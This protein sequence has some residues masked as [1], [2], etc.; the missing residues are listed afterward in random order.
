MAHILEK[1]R[2]WV[3]AHPEA[4]LEDHQYNKI[5]QDVKRLENGEPLPYV[6]GHWEFYGLDFYLTPDVLIPRPETELL[7]ERAIR[8][9]QDSI[10]ICERWW[11]L[12]LVPGVSGLPW[13]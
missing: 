8:W 13:L 10:H 5:I 3:M 2:S 4:Q 9:L 12:A 6:I 7:V 11:M 1:P